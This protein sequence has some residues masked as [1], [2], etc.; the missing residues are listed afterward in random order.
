MSRF[1]LTFTSKSIVVSR[2]HNSG[3]VEFMRFPAGAEYLAYRKVT[4]QQYDHSLR[5]SWMLRREQERN[6]TNV[7]SMFHRA[8]LPVTEAVAKE[9]GHTPSYASVVIPS[10]FSCTI[11]QAATDG[12]LEEPDLTYSW[13]GLS[14]QAICPA[15]DFLSCK[16][17]G[18]NSNE[19]F[20]DGPLNHIFALEYEDDCMYLWLRVVE[21]ELQTYPTILED[22]R[23]ECG[24]LYRRVSFTTTFSGIRLMFSRN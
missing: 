10:I 20:N 23:K 13:A 12:I 6:I 9:I 15:Y 5:D 18:R 11:R 16:K 4:V 1:G 21:F 22:Y 14:D 2:L 24:A 17:L 7:E 3:A 8:A 19:C